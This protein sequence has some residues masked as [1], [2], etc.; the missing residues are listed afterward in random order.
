MPRKK[1][2]IT[3]IDVIIILGKGVASDG[4]IPKIVQRQI[5][6]AIQLSNDKRIPII[7]SGKHWGL[8]RNPA[9]KYTEAAGMKKYALQHGANRTRLLIE[10]QSHDTIGNA[11]FSRV[12]IDQHDWHN[13]LVFATNWHLPRVKYIFKKIYPTNYKLSYRGFLHHTTLW[14]VWRHEC[15]A[16]IFAWIFLKRSR[17]ALATAQQRWLQQQSFMYQP[18]LSKQWLSKLLRHPAHR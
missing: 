12:I 15:I 11:I 17:P 9:I 2:K 1:T 13:I 3:S 6:T 7:L 18:T 16:F 5:T 14:H 8:E 10:D 4:S